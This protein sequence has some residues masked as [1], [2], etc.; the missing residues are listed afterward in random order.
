MGVYN[1]YTA[2]DTLTGGARACQLVLEPFGPVDVHEFEF[3]AANTAHLARHG[4][5]QNDVW[6]V[7]GDS[8]VVCERV[9]GDGVPSFV[10]IG[11]VARGEMWTIVIWLA[12]DTQWIW[13]PITGWRS[14]PKEVQAWRGAD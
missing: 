6:D 13:R 9:Q 7:W 11:E 14:T 3:D 8:P 4:L 5:D 1:V 10:M 12:D 2:D